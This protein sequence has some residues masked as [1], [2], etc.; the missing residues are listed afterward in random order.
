M[1]GQRR[2]IEIALGRGE[3]VILMGD[4][5]RPLQSPIPSF[6]TKLLLDWEKTGQVKILNN[7][8]VHTRIDPCTKKGS[9]LDVGVISINLRP[10]VTGF[11]VDTNKEWTPFVMKGE[12]SGKK[13]LRPPVGE[14][15]NENEKNPRRKTG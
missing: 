5:N 8:H 12:N 10:N 13:I 1:F 9:T 15:V 11:K 14:N 2:R 7:K 6:G 3:E 4:L